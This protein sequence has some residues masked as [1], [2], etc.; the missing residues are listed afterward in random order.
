MPSINKTHIGYALD[1]LNYKLKLQGLYIKQITLTD[2]DTSDCEWIVEEDN[3][4]KDT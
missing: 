3:E 2:K 4:N 1:K